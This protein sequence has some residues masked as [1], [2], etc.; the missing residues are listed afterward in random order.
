MKQKEKLRWY[1]VTD[2]AIE[3]AADK[4]DLRRML[5]K[6]DQDNLPTVIRGKVIKFKFEK[7]IVF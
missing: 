4:R 2:S 3:I 1:I 5:E 6:Y 7:R